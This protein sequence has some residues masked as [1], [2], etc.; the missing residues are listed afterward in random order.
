MSSYIGQVEVNSTLFPV[1]SRLYGTCS[2]NA[3]EAAKVVTSENFDTLLLG[4]TIHVK[5]TNSNTAE[6]PTLNV[7]GTGAR[8]LYLYGT[9]PPGTTEQTSWVPGSVLAITYDGQNWILNDHI[10]DTNTTYTAASPISLTGT[11]FGHAASG[12]TSGTYG[13]DSSTALE[14]D[15]GDTF[16]VPGF[17]VDA[18]GHV[19]SA[20]D[21]TVKIP[22]D[23]ATT[24]SAGLESAADK[25][26]LEGIE[27][28]AQVNTVTGVKGDSESTY[29]TGNINITKANVGLGNVNNTSDVDKPISTATQ[30]ALD[31]KLASTLKG[32]ASGLAE[33]DANGTVPTSQLPSF[34]DDVLEYASQSNFPATGETGKIYIALDTNLTYRWSGTVYVEISASL[35]LGETSST[36]Y[37]G[38]RGATAYSHATDSNRLTTAQTA[39]LYKIATTSEG[40]IASAAAVTK[41]DITDLGI[42]SDDTT[43]ENK[44]ASSG[45][46]DVSLVTTGDKYN[47]NQKT[48]NTGTVTSVATGAGLTGGPITGSGTVK[49][50]LASE[51]PLSNQATAATE[52]SDRV[53]PVALD[54]DGNLAVVVPWT[55]S[56]DGDTKNTAGA[57]DSSSKLF[58]IGAPTQ[59]ANPQ[60]YS[61]DTAYIGTDGHLYSD[62]KQVVNLSGSQ[63]LTNKTYNGYTLA[64]ACAKSV[65]DSSSASAISTGTSLTTERDIYY[66]LP[67]ING[68]HAY[69]SS[70]N[71][72]APTVV[73]TSGYMLVSSGSGAPSW[74]APMSVATVDSICTW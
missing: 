13:T 41:S 64:D 21:H 22:D 9:T 67:T 28:G 71:I 44:A 72:Y 52:S 20:S 48:S 34:V 6:N 30:T 63:A 12:A 40:H 43:Y 37:R 50:A 49:A 74:Q 46:T 4:I 61:Q 60:T 10:N 73:G 53:Y 42:P 36:A 25:T 70:T 1:G 68:S 32:A 15:F 62:S 47:W 54:A 31:G 18:N 45:G 69:T 8:P 35:A 24:S 16:E 26:K 7:N 27:A 51:T 58:I 19:T 14:P 29:R 65:T 57:T 3:A 38:D 66:G 33:L 55:S 56:T 23:V 17:A 59:G 11:Q 5:F 39:G 2:T